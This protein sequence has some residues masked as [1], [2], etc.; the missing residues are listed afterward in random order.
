MAI[1]HRL[2]PDAD[3]HEPKG[4][5][6][7]ANHSVYKANGVGSGAWGRIDTSDFK[8]S[9]GDAGS[10]NKYMRSDGANGVALKTDHAHGVMAFTNNGAN[11]AVTA[12]VDSTLATNSDYVL[13]TGAGAP[14][15]SESLFGGMT[16]LTDRLIV[17]VTGVY[18]IDLWANIVSYPTNTAKIGAKYRVNGATFGPRNVVTKSNSAGDFGQL[19]GFGLASLNA[20]DYV[21]LYIA[22]SATGNLIISNVNN[23]LQLVRET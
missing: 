11:F 16:F 2:I 14:W 4:V 23:L 22:S 6:A 10:T 5:I 7:A 19:N 17:P 12:A 1:E 15:V 20:G 13:F 18:R 8:N 9:I 3:L 21:Q